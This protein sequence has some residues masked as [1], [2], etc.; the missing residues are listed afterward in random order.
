M[1]FMEIDGRNRLARM[2]LPNQESP[3]DGDLVRA[4]ASGDKGALRVVW[5][6]YVTA[7]R[8]TLRAS[9]GKDHGIDDLVQEVF[10]ILYRSAAKLRDPSALRPY[11]LGVAVRQAAFELRTRTRRSRWHLLFHWSTTLGR[12]PASQP[13]VDERDALC[14]LTRLLTFLPERERQAFILRYVQDLSPMEVAQSLGVSKGTAKKAIA[15]GRRRVH[16]RAQQEPALA[17]YLGSIRE[18]A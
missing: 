18:G 10:L 6:R 12:E 3:A 4:I 16:L 11:L 8:A 1:G 7:V 17:Q 15:E 5:E 2:R 14:A 9:L 13:V